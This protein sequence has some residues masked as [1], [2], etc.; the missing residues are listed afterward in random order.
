V[1]E[2]AEA[3]HEVDPQTGNPERCWYVPA[4]NPSAPEWAQQPWVQEFER[5]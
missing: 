3:G 1:R 2:F 4:V 5:L